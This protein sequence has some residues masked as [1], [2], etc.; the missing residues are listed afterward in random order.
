MRE[1]EPGDS[2]SGKLRCPFRKMLSANSGLFAT[3]PAVTCF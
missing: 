3:H 2:F 1:Q